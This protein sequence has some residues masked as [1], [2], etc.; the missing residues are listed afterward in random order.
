VLPANEGSVTTQVADSSF[1]TV[2]R[3]RRDVGAASYVGL[4]YTGRE[5]SDYHNRLGG[6]D[7]FLQLS[8]S[9]SLRAQYVF[10]ET[11]Y[12]AGVAAQFG[13]PTESFSG[14]GLDVQ[15]QHASR[16]W[17]AFA[18]YEDLSP[19]FRADAGF[20][21][22]VDQ[23]DVSAGLVRS[24][25][26]PR[27]GTWYTRINVGVNGRAT[28]KYDG[29]LTDRVVGANVNYL[30]PLQTSLTLF[31]L[32]KR[33]R[34]RGVDHELLEMGYMFSVRPSGAIVAGING[35]VG[36]AVDVVN[37]R[38]SLRIIA[39]PN[40]QLSLGRS[41]T[42]NFSHVYQRLMFQGRHVFT[43][44]L[45]QSRIFF[46][47]S[48][49][50][51]V[52]AVVQFQDVRRNLAEFPVAVPQKSQS[53]FTQLLFSYKLNP[54]TVAFVGYA[55]DRAGVEGVSLTQTGRTFF[56]KLGYALRP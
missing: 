45:A 3:Y 47:F 10:S 8:R 5:G 1:T 9:N 26:A 41:L 6:V 7:A 40:L 52:R 4:L 53:L 51:H 35:H 29:T 55:D 42:L 24:I 17:I 38:P 30:G 39:A 27:R 23:R 32:Q 43:A 36:E 13:Q 37:N 54:Q 31:G 28:W 22:R 15:F 50:A 48:T 11:A 19:E 33:E 49:R 25:W 34:L 16:D 2:A 12:P 44:N 21:P 46:H 56:V 14:G 18:Q 20:V